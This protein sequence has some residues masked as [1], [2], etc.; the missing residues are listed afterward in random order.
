[1]M[2][3]DVHVVYEDC[4][5]LVLAALCFRFT[6]RLCLCFI[7]FGSSILAVV[8]GIEAETACIKLLFTQ[9]DDCPS[10]PAACM[11]GTLR[12]RFTITITCLRKATSF[13]K[14]PQHGHGI[15]VIKVQ[16]NMSLRK[17]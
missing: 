17:L 6:M 10:M 4:T 13:I 8:V 15:H 1:M 3:Y 7:N 9:V 16:C 2:I 5:S 11:L 14:M 12:R